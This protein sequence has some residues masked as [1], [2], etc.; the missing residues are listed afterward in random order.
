MRLLFDSKATPAQPRRY[1][2][3]RFLERAQSGD[4]LSLW[5]GAPSLQG[6]SGEALKAELAALSLIRD[7]SL[8]LP[9]TPGLRACLDQQ[10]GDF[11]NFA[12]LWEVLGEVVAHSHDEQYSSYGLESQPDFLKFLADFLKASFSRAPEE[13]SGE[14][15]TIA[16]R[17]FLMSF[18]D[19]LNSGNRPEHLFHAI[20]YTAL[21]W[22]E[23]FTIKFLWWFSPR[24]LVAI[25]EVEMAKMPEE[26]Q[27]SDAVP[28]SLLSQV[29][30]EISLSVQ[31]EITDLQRD[32]LLRSRSGLL[33]W[34]GLNAIWRQL[35][36]P[37]TRAGALQRVDALSGAQRLCA[38]GWLVRHAARNPKL[39]EI[40]DDLR[41]A[42]LAT[43]PAKVSARKLGDLVDA[44]RGHMRA[45]GWAEPWLS[46]DILN[47]LLQDERASVDD[48]CGIW[49]D[50]LLALLDPEPA[51][52][53]RLFDGA[54]EGQTT[55]VAA[56]LFAH[57]SSE[58]QTSSLS[59]IAPILRRQSR[60]VQQP[61]ASTSDWSR[62]D[63]ALMVITHPYVKRRMIAA[64]T[65]LKP[66]RRR[67]RRR[68]SRP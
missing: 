17:L 32:L 44:L 38:L 62:W 45:I 2:P 41:A 48:A 35:E 16:A 21:T 15:A 46:Q 18:T 68:G 12:V 54:R 56:F 20:K 64:R 67:S 65:A 59:L 36:P 58:R 51:L 53:S 50:E 23:Y 47:P 63:T 3:L 26:L 5:A 52:Q 30:S 14:W 19:L 4:V 11:A 37:G 40:Y 39:A 60:I 25:A 49:I 8:A 66:G 33:Q 13:T 7:G 31:F 22:S 29:I 61:L 43:L 34:M 55:N 9:D 1:E 57:S 10:A 28:M 24:D 42:L 6:L 27:G